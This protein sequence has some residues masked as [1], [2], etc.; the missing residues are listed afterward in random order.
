MG[1]P[2]VSLA[3]HTARERADEAFSI[4]AFIA[5]HQQKSLLR[6]IA[7]G[8]VDHGKSTLIGRLLY[9]SGQLFDDQVAALQSDTNKFS[10]GEDLDYSLLL[11]GL[12]AEREQKIT[13][14]VAYRFFSTEKRKFI[15]IDA[16]G[17]E[18][19]T[20]NMATGASN[21]DV[22]LLLVS[23]SEGLTRQTKRHAVIVSSLG[24]REL[25]VAVNKMDAVSWSRERFAAIEA[26]FRAF[27]KSLSVDHITFIPISARS[28]DN[29][30]TGSRA[31]SWYDGPTLLAYLETVAPAPR[32]VGPFRMPVQ[33]VN[34]P[35]A[36]FRGYCGLIAGG[37]VDVGMP[38]RVLPSGQ[39]THV[40]SIVVGGRKDAQASAGQSVTLTFADEIDASRGDMIAAADAPMGVTET[41][42]ARVFWMAQE[43]LAPGHKYL[44]KIGACTASATAAPNL[45]RLDLDTQQETPAATLAAND[46]G[47]CEL[48]LDRPIAVEPYAQN[49]ETGGFILID[50]ETFE[51]VG[52]GTVTA[53]GEA[54]KEAAQTRARS[55]WFGFLRRG[56]DSHR[57]SFAKAVSWR[58]TG[59]IDTFVLAWIITGN[60]KMA[61]GVAFAEIFTKVALYYGHERIWALVPWG[62]K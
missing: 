33:W 52:L 40:A 61:G 34:R 32:S 16:P 38:V 15:V 45:Q 53:V 59:S 56:S 41:V 37:T 10:K 51:T 26:D 4:D 35:D 50:P 29:V 36:D 27:A 24:V 46:I 47:S 3:P 31:M 48:Q 43:A 9:E 2:S 54:R 11:D 12:A 58:T 25:L 8:S 6:F 18:Q 1:R 44:M 17:H 28:G 7:C 49:R 20:P 21:A 5:E 55:S 22:A 62:R 60:P 19:Y 23:A 30:T 14:D 42:T 57:R 39:V 13:I